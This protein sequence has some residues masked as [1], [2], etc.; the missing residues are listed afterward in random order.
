MVGQRELAIVG[1]MVETTVHPAAHKERNVLI[2]TTVVDTL[3]VLILQLESLSAEVH[4]AKALAGANKA[5][6]G[7]A[8]EGDGG[9]LVV[10][11][12]AADET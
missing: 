2:A 7:S 3:S 1:S 8:F 9:S 11:R 12:I 5:L 10:C 4:L 6:V